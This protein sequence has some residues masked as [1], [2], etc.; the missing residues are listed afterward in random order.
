MNVIARAFAIC[1]YLYHSTDCVLHFLSVWNV[2]CRRLDTRGATVAHNSRSAGLEDRY[3]L[4]PAVE[5]GHFGSRCIEPRR[6][7]QKTD[8]S[9][10]NTIAFCIMYSYNYDRITNQS[11]PGRPTACKRALFLYKQMGT[12]LFVR[13]YILLSI[14]RIFNLNIPTIF[15]YNGQRFD[16]MNSEWHM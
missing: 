13:P 5:L 7:A 10:V 14:L 3:W 16:Y 1:L 15:H 8:G 4:R 12:G 11:Q 6:L 9:R 2:W